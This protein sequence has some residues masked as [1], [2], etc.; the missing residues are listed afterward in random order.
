M[1]SPKWVVPYFKLSIF[2]PL[3]MAWCIGYASADPNK[4]VKDPH[5]DLFLEENYP[6][7]SQCS[8]CHQKIYKEWASSNHAY[9]SISPMFHKFEQA[10]YD[11]T[12]G[13]IGSFCV[14]C[15]QQVGTQRGEPREAPLW[16]RSRV[17]R[18]G[19]T[20]ITCHRVT[21]QFGKVNGERNII[22]GNIH[23][24]IYNTA[25]G[26]RFEDIL[27]NKKELRIATSDKE[28]GAKIHGKV[29][30]FAQISKSEFCVSCHQVAVN[31]GIK[32]E[33]VWDQYRA[34]P[35][36]K[37]GVSCQACHMGKIAGVDS[38]YE[39]A[40]VAIV[41]GKEISPDRD[42]HNHAFYGPGYPIAHPGIFPHN[43]DAEN[44][45]IQDWLKFDWRAGWGKD[46]FE[47][48]VEALAEP[49][50]GI[51]EAA[52]E[53]GTLSLTRGLDKFDLATSILKKRL[54]YKDRL[55]TP[56]SDAKNALEMLSEAVEADQDA[57]TVK[58]GIGDNLEPLEEAISELEGKQKEKAVNALAIL[59]EAIKNFEGTWSGK[60]VEKLY[61]KLT[62]LVEKI[63]KI[64]D[65][66]ERKA[67]FEELTN[68]SV[69]LR[70]LGSPGIAFYAKIVSL[71]TILNVNFP[72]EWSDPDDRIEAREV[73]EANLKE[74]AYKKR[75]REE[76]MNNG[77]KIDG[78]F[79]TNKPEVG[80]SLSLKY[81][82][83]NL[84]NGHNLPSGSLG[85]QPEIWLNVALTD[86]D[87]NNVWE[88]GY[89]D[90]YG[91]FADNHSLDVAEGKIKFDDQ[92]FNLQSKFLTTNI[93]GTDREMYLPVNFDIDQ[94]P[95]LRAAGQPTTV[96]NHPPFA[97]MEARSIPPLGS[98]DAKY[99]IPSTAFKKK[100]KYKLSVRLR[101]RAEPIYFM[102]FVGAT[103]EMIQSMN[104]WMVDIHPY[105]VEFDVN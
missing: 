77:G 2:V 104:Q 37:D 21:E 59:K 87:G 81:V 99:R 56:V 67:I 25:V 64:D 102:K 38:G 60:G 101:S 74:L 19:I 88:S 98:K 93:K 4:M 36:A 18:E 7:A 32:L 57:E 17:A 50:E 55:K 52:N 75:L 28:R 41:G 71:K 58:E 63:E 84:N 47:E 48:S 9:A 61:T 20:C 70:K 29:I 54:A 49:F 53:A 15:H 16:E 91:D 14:R 94:R 23:A 34:S 95:L 72:D 79:F 85:A 73:V 13:T 46:E 100:G 31:L 26:S 45:T 44:W 103:E 92:I 96:M 6:S 86:P 105:T 3:L 90:S 8:V 22:P 12:Q 62:N 39:K 33:V 40:P 5:A 66:S 42:H 80:E 83:T 89:V 10:I 1:K 68:S 69:A 65:E 30:K 43:P 76:V 78:P 35:A 51:D 24:P 11:L 27:K 97:R 82:V